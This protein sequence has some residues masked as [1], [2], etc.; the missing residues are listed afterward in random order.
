MKFMKRLVA[1]SIVLAS[2]LYAT[3]ASAGLIVNGGFETGDLAGWTISHSENNYVDVADNDYVP[4]G[5]YVLYT[6]CVDSLCSTSQAIATTP[7]STY[8]FSFEYG[9]DGQTPNE[10]MAIFN[11]IT[12]F[13]SFDDDVATAPGFAHKSFNVVATGA[14]TMVEF[15]A[16]NPNGFFALDDVSVTAIPEPGVLAL[17]LAGLAGLMISRRARK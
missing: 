2:G 14:S 1:A 13:H 6:G 8:V 16:T 7:G 12:L 10:F 5:T 17:L 11:G 9:N 15:L 3:S 4:F